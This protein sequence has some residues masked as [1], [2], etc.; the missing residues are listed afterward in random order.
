MLLFVL[1]GTPLVAYLWETLNRALAG[2]I[3]G[4]RLLLAIPVL[5]ALAWLLRV[6][7][8]T[9]WQWEGER[10]AAAAGAGGHPR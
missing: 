7:R 2:R 9:V 5:L 6:L 8:R 10:A 1:A 3:E 4:R